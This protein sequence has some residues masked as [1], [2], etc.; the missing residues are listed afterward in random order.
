[1]MRISKFVIANEAVAAWPPSPLPIPG[2]CVSAFE[3]YCNSSFRY[4]LKLIPVYVGY[5]LSL[6]IC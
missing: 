5:L 1:M 6:K 3:K 4:L 2:I